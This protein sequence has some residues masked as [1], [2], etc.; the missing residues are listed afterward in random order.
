MQAVQGFET[1]KQMKERHKSSKS[2]ALFVP[3]EE[4]A[5]HLLSIPNWLGKLK[6]STRLVK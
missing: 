2:G 6:D 4:Q 5:S 1:E 3:I